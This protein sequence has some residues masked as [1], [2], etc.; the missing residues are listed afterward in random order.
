MTVKIK[1]SQK[2]KQLIHKITFI[3]LT[4]DPYYLHHIQNIFCQN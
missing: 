4:I 3:N 2:S 1:K